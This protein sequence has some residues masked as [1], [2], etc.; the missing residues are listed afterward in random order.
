MPRVCNHG[1]VPIVV[2]KFGGSSVADAEKI[3]RCAQRAFDARQ[4]GQDVV[5][6]VSAMGKTTDGLIDLAHE[7]SASPPRREMDQLLAAGEQVSIALAA[8]ALQELGHEAV[9][10][11]GAQCGL[12]TDASFTSA[13]IKSIDRR[14]IERHLEAG[15]IVVVAGFQGVDEDGSTTTLGRGGSDTTAVAL[16]AALEADVCEICTDVRGVFTADPRI[17]PDARLLP[18]ISYEEM[19]E[20]AALGAQIVAPRA[21]FLGMKFAVPIHVRHAMLPD[22]GTMIV[23]ETST[24]EQNEVTGVALKNGVGRVTMQDLP[25]G[26]G[27]QATI[28][29]A[30]ADAQLFVD[31]IIQNR[32]DDAR[33]SITFTADAADLKDARAALQPLVDR[34]GGRLRV[35]EDLCRVSAVGVGMRTHSGVAAR[36]FRALEEAPGGPITIENITTSEIKIA[37][38]LPEADGPRAVRAVHDAFGLGQTAS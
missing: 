28:F 1:P 16:A 15:K 2:Q 29:D 14:Q 31:D 22:T 9:S 36:M 32:V 35:D 25:L 6:V 37:C 23:Q 5:V 18:E 19:F 27:I 34:I 11:T 7:I 3:R 10:L 17:V 24:M 33:M 4:A 12:R 38:I 30:L 20:L 26:N 21:V 8:M 13:R